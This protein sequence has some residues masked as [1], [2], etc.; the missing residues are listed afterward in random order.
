MKNITK[1]LTAFFLFFLFSLPTPTLA[2]TQC[3][4]NDDCQKHFNDRVGCSMTN[5]G[6][7]VIYTCDPTSNVNYIDD[8]IK[9]IGIKATPIDLNNSSEGT[10][11]CFTK[12]GQPGVNTALGCISTDIESGGFVNTIL[13]LAIGLGGTIAL[14]LI[15]IGVFIITTSA[16]IPDKLNQGK[17]LITSAV[18]GLLFIILSIFLLNLIGIQILAIPGF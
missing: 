7:G 2:A 11:N 12:D 3:T 6:Q 14:L 16:G 17:E 15:L 1:V 9:N 13:Q 10:P 18:S 4:S 5:I 8:E